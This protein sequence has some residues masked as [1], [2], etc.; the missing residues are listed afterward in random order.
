MTAL[1]R[2]VSRS[3]FAFAIPSIWTVSGRYPFVIDA[4]YSCDHEVDMGDYLEDDTMKEAK[5][6][7]RNKRYYLA[8]PEGQPWE[9]FEGG[10][11]D[12]PFSALPGVDSMGQGSFGNVTVE[13]IIIGSVRTYLQNGETNGDSTA[14]PADEST[15][16]DLYNDDITTPGIIRLPV[17]TV[18][19]AIAIFWI[20]TRLTTR[21]S[22]IQRLTIVVP[23]RLLYQTSDASPTV[24]DCMQMVEWGLYH[25]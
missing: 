25:D 7:Y 19:A 24:S 4:G 23:P 3:F 16:D 8:A 1:R 15:L 10:C 13:E 12:N 18:H 22:L 9:C 2:G 14:D 5:A 6:C 11:I 21:V 20:L 17:L